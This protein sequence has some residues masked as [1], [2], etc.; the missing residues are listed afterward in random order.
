MKKFGNTNKKPSTYQRPPSGAE[1]VLSPTHITDLDEPD[2]RLTTRGRSN[3][4]S[5]HLSRTRISSIVY[6]DDSDSLGLNDD[7]AHTTCLAMN[8]AR[9]NYGAP[10][11]QVNDQLSEIAQRWANEMART[12]KLEHSPAESRNFGRQVLGENYTARFQ[13]ELTR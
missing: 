2:G 1:R 13:S 5:K 3:L 8:A 9:Q 7:F 12:G 11:L 10:P 6:I 4:S